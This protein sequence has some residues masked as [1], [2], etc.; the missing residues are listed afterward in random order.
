MLTLIQAA[1]RKGG[2]CGRVRSHGDGR[3]GLRFYNN[4]LM[5]A[6]VITIDLSC[7]RNLR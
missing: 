2:A 5:V 1:V 4:N 6:I 7:S 3:C